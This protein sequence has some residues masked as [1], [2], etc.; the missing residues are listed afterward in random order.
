MQL[1][2]DGGFTIEG[3]RRGDFEGVSVK[4]LVSPNFRDLVKRKKT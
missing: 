4:P 2:K 1:L 3:V